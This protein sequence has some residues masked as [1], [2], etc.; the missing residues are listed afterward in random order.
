MKLCGRRPQQPLRPRAYP[1]R[2]RARGRRRRGGGA[3]RAQRRRQV[4]DVPL[5]R[6]PGRAA[7]R[8][9]RVRGQGRLARADARD[10]AQRARLRAGGAAHLHRP[11]GGGKSRSRPPA[12]AAERAA[13]DARKAVRAVSQSRRDAQPPGRTHERRRAADADDRAHADGQS[14]AG[15]AGRAVGRAVA[16]DRRADGR[17]HPD[18]EEGRRQHRRLRAEPA[19]RAD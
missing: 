17:R 15:A 11:D 18:H 19:F 12:E 1:V 4:D 14:V 10:R 3:A 6:R 7:L 2:Y 9:H 16:E 13:L 8:A 5:D